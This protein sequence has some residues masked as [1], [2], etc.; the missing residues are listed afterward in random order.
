LD[1]KGTE[2]TVIHV[3]PNIVPGGLRGMNPKK[4]WGVPLVALVGKSG[5]RLMLA[6]L[7][8]P[9]FEIQATDSFAI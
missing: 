7:L 5:D 9:N 4:P 1:F 8:T 3:V 6:A 2:C